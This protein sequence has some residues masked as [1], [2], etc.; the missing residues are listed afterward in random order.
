MTTKAIIPS[1]MMCNGVSMPLFGLGTAF[2]SFGD[3]AR[4]TCGYAY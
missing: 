1:V 4:S 2:V 3:I